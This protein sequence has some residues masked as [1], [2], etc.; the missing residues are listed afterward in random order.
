[1]RQP[2]LMRAAAELFD[3]ALISDHVFLLP[4]ITENED[5][6]GSYRAAVPIP[7]WRDEIH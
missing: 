1:M 6:D 2:S 3:G 7:F 4:E 5:I